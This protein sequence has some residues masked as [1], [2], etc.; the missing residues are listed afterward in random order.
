MEQAQVIAVDHVFAGLASE[1]VGGVAYQLIHDGWGVSEEK[2]AA[3][4]RQRWAAPDGAPPG[5]IPFTPGGKRVMELALREALQLGMSY[6]GTEHLLLGIIR[7]ASEPESEAAEMWEALELG[8]LADH[9]ADVIRK[10]TENGDYAPKN[11]ERTRGP[12]VI[13]RTEL[14]HLR[15]ALDEMWGLMP[16]ELIQELS[17]RTVDIARLNH[18]ALHHRETGS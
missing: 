15:E 4:C 14:A 18:D 10:L 8:V 7:M 5:H 16:S 12:G 9:K 17:R 6:I 2:V 3:R 1:T 11:P 13:G